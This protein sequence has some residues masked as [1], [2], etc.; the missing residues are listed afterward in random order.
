M[1]SANGGNNSLMNR[2]SGSSAP[3]RTDKPATIKGL[4]SDVNVKKRFEE[5]LGKKAAGFMSSLISVTNGNSQLQKADP[6]TIVAAGAIAAALDLPVDPNLGFAYIVP[7]NTK[8]KLPDGTDT[9]VNQAQFQIGYKGYI[10]LAMRTGQYKTINASEVYEGEIKSI[11]RFTGEIEFGE[12]TSDNVVGYIAFFRLLN[13]FEKYLYMTKDEIEKHGKAFSK[14]F[15]KENGLWKKD[16]HAMAIKT[17]IKRLL[18]KYGIL[19]IEMQTSLQADQAIV[20][21]NA[22]GD[23][24]YDYVDGT[25]DIEGQTIDAETGEILQPDTTGETLKEKHARMTG[26]LKDSD[27]DANEG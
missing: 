22:D 26:R 24:T 21:E 9:W 23:T 25:I 8:K 19:S 11:N 1:A 27:G 17:V 4:L 7:Y 10:Q 15:N 20:R 5:L 14:S 12:Q 2:M 6:N 16:F 3:A 18:S 13:G